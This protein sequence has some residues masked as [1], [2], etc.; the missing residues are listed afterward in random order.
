MSEIDRLLYLS[1]RLIIP[2]LP[3]YRKS[4]IHNQQILPNEKNPLKTSKNNPNTPSPWKIPQ[5]IHQP[6]KKLNTPKKK[7]KKKKNIKKQS[8]K[9]NQ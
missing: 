4:L 5:N 2:L 9:H 6:K 1:T 8:S 7:E 3:T